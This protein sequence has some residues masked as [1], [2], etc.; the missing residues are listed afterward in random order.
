MNK[1][2]LGKAFSLALFILA[3]ARVASAQQASLT[4][5]VTDKSEA[6][7][8][9][10][11][12]K[13]TNLDTGITRHSETNGEGFFTA[14]FL[15]PGSYRVTV[16]ANGFK[17]ATRD[18]LQL[19]LDQVTRA[20]F[21]LEPGAVS[22]TV[23]VTAEAP[24]LQTD[25]A[26]LG[27]AITGK[28]VQDLP[29][30]GRN[31]IQ[32]VQ[33]VPGV[34]SGP[35]NGLATG[36]RPDERRLNASYSVNGQDPIV[37][38]NMIDGLDNNERFIGTVVVR[39]SIDAIQEF[40]VQT[41]LYS[42][43]VSRT[44]GGVVNILTKSGANDFHG[45]LFEFL[46]NDIFDANG[47]Y[48]FTGGA[49]LPK[50]KYR[51]NQFGG[52]IGGPIIK[53]R[54]F[55]FSDYEALRI[56]QGIPITATIPTAKQ[57]IGDFS[58]NCTAGFNASGICANAAQ[59]LSFV[60]AIG[61]APAGAAPFNRLD[62][63]VYAAL[64]D[65]VALKY[66]AL[67]PPPTGPGINTT[68]FASSPVRP[69]DASTFDARIDH[70]FNDK[71]SFFGRYSFN[72]V[73]TVQPTGFPNVGDVNPGGLF[74]FA[75]SNETRAQ[76]IQL[77]MV[78][79]LRPNLLLEL[80]AGYTRLA[81]QS[82]TVNSGKNSANDLGFACNIT[83]C[84]NVGDTQTFGLPRL[85]IQGFQDLGDP[86]F[87]PLLI[88]NNTFQYSGALTWTRGAH[89]FKFGASL[90]R[91]QFSPVQ[92][93]RPR[94][95]FTF[96][97]STTNA[98]APLNFGLANFI[99]GAPV[100]IIRQASLYTPGYRTWEHGFYAQDDWRVNNWLTLNLGV[101][102]DIFTPKTEAYNRLANFDPTTS[103]VLIAGQNAGKTA[104]VGTDYG[105]FAPRVGFAATLG[106]GLVMRGGFGLSYFPGDYASPAVLKNPPF[107]SALT[108]GTSTTGNIAGNNCPAGTG[109]FSQ[110]APRPLDPNAFPTANGTLDLTRIPPST[111]LAVELEM[112]ASYNL[113]FNLTLE[114]QFGSNV[115]SV[116]YVGTKG[117]DLPMVIPDINRA[118]P[119]GT[120]IPNPRPFASVAP[121]LT[122]IG[123]FVSQGSASYNALQLTFNRRFTKGLSLTSGYTWAH[124]IDDTTANGTST[125]GYG[126]LIGPL[127]QA[128]ANIKSYDRATS[129]FNI[130]HRW[131]F[132]ANY[133]LPFGKDLK[134]AAGQAFS[135]W[136]LNG[137][138]I[139]QT[140]LPFTVT[141]QQAVSGI[142]GG[143]A[144]RPNRLRE[145]LRVS[146]PTVGVA[147]QFLDPAAFALPAPF[148]L[149][150]ATRNVGY[151]PN[152]SA[153]NM[154]LF[155]TFKLAESWNLQFRT[156]VFNLP[157]H[158]VFGNPNTAFGNANFGK[159]STTAGMY[160]PRQIQ[161][162][163]KLLF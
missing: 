24:A 136:Q 137:S 105:N 106:K 74:A 73:T 6:V 69:Q 156:E 68:N 149:G 4:G 45:S 122:T 92:S 57:R 112:Q 134:G 142:I 54:T 19:T 93:A 64:R 113:Q 28:L 108:C 5:R 32:L 123:H 80:K 17:T 90:I 138:V 53:D 98:P 158:P 38:N 13:V 39:P 66:A 150:N 51:Q 59:Q 50:Q 131:S 161:F 91:R 145:D 48:N 157:N 159:I 148:T 89:N 77:N 124:G 72:D 20:D 107:T 27:T 8:A 42:A 79:T 139:W 63:G 40:R 62:Q 110:G 155:K 100:T 33:L 49:T 71:T 114:K 119:S 85:V 81:L 12:V 127:A 37:N 75:G 144:E 152:Q 126:N 35:P 23:Q 36:T 140:G 44:S 151:G 52:S 15:A 70:R 120:S 84:V 86:F 9:G 130:K 31:Y 146:N 154:S 21:S 76:N 58:E 117:Y 1:H 43:E 34:S 103:T 118:L 60:N 163:L 125:G 147:G 132:G 97:A 65:P 3:F 111:M 143:G 128:I 16:E 26:T 82:L 101:R 83:N 96:N 87:V 11:G 30:N 162:A 56:R 29:L 121:R 78:R 153:V 95:E 22:E 7:V 46:R 104:G 141:D 160:T 55:F 61:G 2:K 99:V 115:V 67:L 41:N 116:G 14:P 94:G 102:Y 25:S 129:D 10:A 133:E 109:V 88:F 18:G 135:G 47:N